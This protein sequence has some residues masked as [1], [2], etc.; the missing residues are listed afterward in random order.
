VKI[1]KQFTVGPTT[2][3][4]EWRHT[5]Q[6]PSAM[7]RTYYR[8]KLV[9]MAQ[10]DEFGNSFEQ[11]EIDDTFWHELTHII[12]QDMGH[13]LTDN[14]NFVTAFANRLTQAVNSSKL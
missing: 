6:N 2:Y 4:V 9:E 12:L 7:G 10:Y 8:K 5:I 13:D 14:E 1:P 11:E 3:N